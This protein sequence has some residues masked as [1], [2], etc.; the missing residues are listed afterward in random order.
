MNVYITDNPE[1]HKKLSGESF[2]IYQL[3]DWRIKIEVT[4]TQSGLIERDI[5]RRAKRRDVINAI[6]KND[7]IIAIIAPSNYKLIYDLIFTKKN[8]GKELKF[9][10]WDSWGSRTTIPLLSSSSS[11][12]IEKEFDNYLKRGYL[13]LKLFHELAFYNFTRIEQF[14]IVLKIA[15]LNSQIQT[16]ATLGCPFEYEAKLPS[17]PYLTKIAS[18]KNEQSECNKVNLLGII[19]VLTFLYRSFS[20][21][22]D[23]LTYH[24]R[25]GDIT[26]PFLGD[27]SFLNTKNSLF[28]IFKEHEKSDLYF[29]KESSPKFLKK[30]KAGTTFVINELCKIIPLCDVLKSI[31]HLD[32][33]NI[34]KIDESGVG[35]NIFTELSLSDLEQYEAFYNNKVWEQA[36]K[37][38]DYSFVRLF[39]NIQAILP[40]FRCPLCSANHFITFPRYFSCDN[41]VCSFYFPRIVKPGG[42]SKLLTELDFLKLLHHGSTDIKNARGGYSKYA[43]FRYEGNKFKAIPV[44]KSNKAEE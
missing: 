21:V 37:S 32:L 14:F 23:K 20:R 24:A 42:V 12:L 39:P 27:F 4:D 44:M 1:M 6:K 22:V 31:R 13:S 36:Y 19:R 11:E 2:L 25:R 9:Y 35:F 17:I 7:T 33:S 5:K 8:F 18:K 38:L 28:K 15:F 34:L 26:D 29:G 43:L 30:H 40:I 41:A 3:Y 10:S 16:G